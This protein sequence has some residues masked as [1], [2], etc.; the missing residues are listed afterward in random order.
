M[1]TTIYI[2]R[3]LIIPKKMCMYGPFNPKTQCCPQ[4]NIN[5]IQGRKKKRK[6]ERKKKRKKKYK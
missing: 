2:L 5:S 6:K 3:R 1:N 4:E